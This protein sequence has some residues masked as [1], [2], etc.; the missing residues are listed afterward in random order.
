MEERTRC[1]RSIYIVIRCVRIGND[2]AV[3]VCRCLCRRG[4][5]VDYIL[6][7][8]ICRVCRSLCRVRSLHR[9]ACV[10]VCLFNLCRILSDLGSRL[11]CGFECFAC[12]LICRL[13]LRG[14]AVRGGLRLLCRLLCALCRRQCLACVIVRG[15]RGLLYGADLPLQGRDIRAVLL[16]V[17]QDERPF[18]LRGSVG[19]HGQRR[20]FYGER[21][22]LGSY[23]LSRRGCCRYADGSR[24]R[25]VGDC[26]GYGVLPHDEIVLGVLHV[27]HRRGSGSPVRKSKANLQNGC[28]RER[29][30]DKHI[31]HVTALINV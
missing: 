17:L 10:F 4:C 12:V 14:K 13:Y 27:C 31:R 20:C 24:A 21:Y 5:A 19:K 29:S 18:V 9:R 15:I 3:S 30:S 23:N 11:I 28:V 8:L 26:R 1:K 22:R 7:V 25:F 2:V 6:H 16:Y